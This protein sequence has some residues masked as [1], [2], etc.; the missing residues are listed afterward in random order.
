MAR[1]QTEQRKL[2]LL[3]FSQHP[4]QQYSAKEIWELVGGDSIS[5]SA[6]YRNL[7]E[8]E[9]LGQLRRC[10]KSGSREAYYQYTNQADCREYLHLTCRRCGSTCHLDLADTNFLV[11]RIAQQNHFSV[12]K[13]DTVIYGICAA[14]QN[15]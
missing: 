6:I 12:D 3:F 7:S 2:L 4:H 13:A 8:L 9:R 5:V 11:G 14:C 10:Q 15:A 1:Y